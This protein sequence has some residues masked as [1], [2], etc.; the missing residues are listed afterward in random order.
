[1]RTSQTNRYAR[2]SAGAACI[3]LVIVACV[4]LHRAWLARLDRKSAPPAIPEEIA[5]RSSGFAFSKVEG[6]R[7][8]FTVRASNATQ[9]KEG[10][11]A[12]L[13]DVWITFYGSDGARNDNLHT[14][15]CDY[16][17]TTN[18][19]TCTADV[20]M[21]LESADEARL[22]P[23]AADGAPS[24]LARVLHISTSGLSF[25]GKSGVTHT[26]RAVNFRFPQGSGRSV[27]LD[28]NANDGVLDLLRD[29]HLEFLPA[30]QPP[31]SGAV[32]TAQQPLELA[33]GSLTFRRAE[34][35]ARLAGPVQAQY[36][37]KTL[38]A[39]AAA[40]ELDQ[41]FTAR[42]I[43]AT[44]NPELSETG[45][46]GSESLTADQLS[47]LFTPDGWIGRAIADGNVRGTH[48][49][50]GEDDGLQA[51]HLELELF[52]ES[53]GQG[54]EGQPKLLTASGGVRA[55]SLAQGSTRTFETSALEVTFVPPAGTTPAHPD[56]LRTLAPASIQW[57]DPPK[58][59]SSAGQQSTTTNLKGQTMEAR[60]NARNQITEI[61]AGGGVDV[62]QNSGT[63][64]PRESS[65]QTLDA[66]FDS[67]GQWSA[68]E[69]NGDVRYHEA[70]RS[71]QAPRAIWD[72]AA[73]TTTLLGGVTIS[74]ATTRTTAQTVVFAQDTGKLNAEGHVLT[75]EIS[76]GSQRIG[77]FSSEPA[78]ITAD[79]LIAERGTQR[80]FYT[81]RARLWQ[82][83]ALMQSDQIELDHAAQTA[84]AT[85]HVQAVFPEAS[86]NAPAGQP[87]PHPGL[88]PT[89][90]AD[91]S[92]RPGQPSQNGR[93]ELWR[94]QGGQLTYWSAR[95]LARLEQNA[96]AESEEAF[97]SAPTMDFFFAP[98]DPQNPSGGQQ[99]VRAAASGG[100]V[101]RQQDRHG[102]SQRAEYTV[103]DRKF[104]LS[105][106]PPVLY[107]D[108]GNTTTGRQ[109]TFIFADDRIVVDSEEGTRTL[110]LHR[111][112]K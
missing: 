68:V 69:Q 67:A 7:T 32:Q 66:H 41:D 72:R 85:G 27:G 50:G 108:S 46:N 71:A 19:M 80:A 2:W 104:V 12:A 76:G 3:L 105:G 35:V 31:K 61:R 60:F 95:S 57:T 90:K 87:A 52:S 44:G 24:P 47:A 29:V 74:D 110:T 59:S 18:V 97:I 70:D 84:T 79:Q 107:D 34:L 10:D 40:L 99:L 16:V 23:S 86:W 112:E 43:V 38:T 4:Y 63:A 15:A 91:S 75:A 45:A 17:A 82:G 51:G 98:A 93:P 54:V 5:A 8:I 11:R 109:L 77:N 14:H 92:P 33:G 48:R 55:T 36:G 37:R 39:Q 102:K 9:F 21:D 88:R 58:E 81:G 106:G 73:S 25:N 94:A 26:D 111:V 64:A 83:D 100:V 22:H 96:S 103:E 101:V 89:P 65:S 13:E 6:D 1:V 53:R 56:L 42:R 49:S 78:R 62:L 28:Y 30:G 20:E